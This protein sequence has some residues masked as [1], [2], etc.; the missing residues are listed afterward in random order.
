MRAASIALVLVVSA[1]CATSHKSFQYAVVDRDSVAPRDAS[2]NEQRLAGLRES[3]GRDF[4]WFDRD[5]AEYIV[6]DAV[7]VAVASRTIEPVRR[8]AAARNRSTQ[9]GGGMALAEYERD[10]GSEP[11]GSSPNSDP[12]FPARNTGME[13]L[14]DAAFYNRK[15]EYQQTRAAKKI[16][17]AMAAALDESLGNGTA[18]RLR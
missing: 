14:N 17:R 16:D 12:A 5:G 1:G 10:H 18:Q 13:Q 2:V 15:L 8:A 9:W 11:I 3:I 7:Q 6:T 4:V